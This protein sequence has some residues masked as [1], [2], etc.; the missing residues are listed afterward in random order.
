M[1]PE[2]ITTGPMLLRH[3]SRRGKLREI[4]LHDLDEIQ[5]R[6]SECVWLALINSMAEAT[7]EQRESALLDG[8]RWEFHGMGVEVPAL[9]NCIRSRASHVK[10]AML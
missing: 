10:T 9:S 1:T 5:T 2:E 3:V 6:L 4:V 7:R 8:A